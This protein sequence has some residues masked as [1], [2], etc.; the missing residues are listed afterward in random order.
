MGNCCKKSLIFD[1][2]LFKPLKNNIEEEIDDGNLNNDTYEQIQNL[3]KITDEI[4]G[5]LILLEQ[6]TTQN[7]KLLSEDIHYINKTN[8]LQS[9]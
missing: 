7:I 6:N 3:F 8:T 1:D 2:Y 9:I 4:N 5:K